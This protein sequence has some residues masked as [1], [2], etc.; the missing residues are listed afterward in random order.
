MK[1]IDSKE[2][3]PLKGYE[4]FYEINTNGDI[5]SVDRVITTKGYNGKG[6]YTSHQKGVLRKSYQN[7][8]G[9]L[10]IKLYINGKEYQEY[11]HRLVYDTFIGNKD[12]KN[13][14]DH[15]D[16]NKLNCSLENLEEITHKENMRRMRKFYGI[17]ARPKEKKS[18]RT[19]TYDEMKKVLERLRTEPM[20]KVCKD[21]GLSDKGLSKRLKSVGLPYQMK[22]INKYFNNN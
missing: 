4:G 3:F 13:D 15:L 20:S 9:Y 11:V 16:H 22:E 19:Y 12:K 8:S 2:F 7:G 10:Q 14:I 17:E 1:E 5:R 21:Y 6:S 18:R